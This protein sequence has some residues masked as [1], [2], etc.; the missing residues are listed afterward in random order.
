MRKINCSLTKPGSLDRAIKD[1]KTYK[2][3]IRDKTDVFIERLALVGVPIIREKI[4]QADTYDTDLDRA[5]YTHI[6]L[7]SFGD[8]HKATLTVEGR[9]ILYFEF[10][11]G[12]HYN[13]N[14]NGSPNPSIVQDVPGGTFYH[15]GG[16]ELGYTIGSF[17]K[18]QGLND[19]WF[20][21]DDS[22]ASQMSH[23][24]QATMPM[25]SAEMEMISKII[26]IAKEVFRNG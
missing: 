13:S 14:P 1:L 4:A 24:T 6:N 26:S 11:A 7:Q 21:Y 19:Y 16:K 10:G 25:Y 15:A 2:D 9:N 18:H 17:G 22:G 8:Y 12:V 20:Y 3:S 5:H 23:G